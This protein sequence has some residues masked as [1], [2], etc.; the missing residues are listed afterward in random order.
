[1][2]LWFCGLNSMLSGSAW[3]AAFLLIPVIAAQPLV[4]FHDLDMEVYDQALNLIFPPPP[5]I[6]KGVIF[7]MRLRFIPAFQPE[8]QLVVVFFGNKPPSVEYLVAE[9]QL[10]RTA[11]ETILAGVEPEPNAIAIAIAI[12][13]AKRITVMRRTF[14]IG[15]SRIL[16]WQEGMFQSLAVTLPRLRGETRE[17]YQRGSG[18]LVLDGTRYDVGYSQGPADFHGRFDQTAYGPAIAKWA[19]SV[20]AEILKLKPQQ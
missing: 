9:K 18:M 19:E 15:S 13:I 10:Y 11:T 16:A 8:S 14:N 4:S 1:M 12:A 3:A 6:E 5:A 17:L 20:R 7:T 2:K